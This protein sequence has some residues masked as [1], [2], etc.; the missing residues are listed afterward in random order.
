MRKNYTF[1]RG[2]FSNCFC[3][4]KFNVKLRK[5]K[6]I[7]CM[8]FENSYMNKKTRKKLKK[9]ILIFFFWLN[10]MKEKKKHSF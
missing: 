2:F 3:F 4:K 5:R 7:S 8:E 9:Q 1:L 6:K 10:F